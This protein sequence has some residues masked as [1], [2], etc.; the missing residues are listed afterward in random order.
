MYI[1]TVEFE[2]AS[3]YFDA[4]REAMFLQAKN[5]LSKESGCKQFDVCF[6]PERPYVCFLYEKYDDRAAFDDHLASEHFAM[7]DETV[8]PWI[9][10]KTV[11][12]WL[13]DS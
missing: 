5:S 12:S 6:H 13:T 9:I 3:D 10:N 4:F 1:I 11:N 7:F 8:K 2:I